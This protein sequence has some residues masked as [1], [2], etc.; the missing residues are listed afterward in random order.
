M[1]FRWRC[2][3]RSGDLGIGGLP[4]LAMSRKGGTL[5]RQ[6]SLADL[7]AICVSE[8]LA[9]ALPESSASIAVP[10][11]SP[12]GVALKPFENYLQIGSLVLKQYLVPHNSRVAPSR[13]LLRSI[14]LE[15]TEIRSSKYP[16]QSRWLAGSVVGF[17]LDMFRANTACH[18]SLRTSHT[19]PVWM[20][21]QQKIARLLLFGDCL[22]SL[23]PTARDLGFGTQRV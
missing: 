16:C 18:A 12:L 10:Y 2:P 1:Q 9:E 4:A 6:G 22:G 7:Q 15:G 23:E 8:E 3:A 17:H 13:V 11:S 21:L 20:G 5:C 19:C 14:P